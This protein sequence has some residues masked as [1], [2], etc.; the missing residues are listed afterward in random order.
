MN[1]VIEQYKLHI[2]RILDTSQDRIFLYWKGRV[3]LYAILKSLGVGKYDEVIIQGF[4][5]VVVSNAILY[6]EAVPVYIDIDPKTMNASFI[7]IKKAINQKTKV[8]ILQNT[9]GLSTELEKI[10]ELANSLGIPTI[11][12]CTHGFGGYYNGKPNG[13]YCDAAFFSTQWNKAISTGIGGFIVVNNKELLDPIQTINKELV[14]PGFLEE[15]GLWVLIKLNHAL[16]NRHTYW[17]L[18]K[19][20]R[21]LSK[22]GLVIGSSENEELGSTRMPVRYFKAACK[23][24]AREGLHQI[25]NLK[26]KIET[27]KRNA[28]YYTDFLRSHGKI[29]VDDTLFKDHSFTK[30]CIQVKNRDLFMKLGEKHMVNLDDWFCSPLHPVKSDLSAWEININELS[31]AKKISS[32]IVNIPTDTHD[33]SRILNFLRTYIDEL[34]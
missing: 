3:G 30:Y 26:D 13:S 19:I 6:L 20:Y 23:V 34:L 18:R 7:N 21:W 11:E 22:M 5:C 16:I 29:H 2:S 28:R 10:I 9:F 12:D 24:Q 15:L 14:K 32:H 25:I 17:I 27:R 33:H 1:N 8:I 31:V 4:T